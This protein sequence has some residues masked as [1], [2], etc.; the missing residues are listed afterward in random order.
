MDNNTLR[1]VISQLIRLKDIDRDVIVETLLNYIG[2][3]YDIT[4]D[5]D[6]NHLDLISPYYWLENATHFKSLYE[7]LCFYDLL[8]FEDI[9]SLRKFMHDNRL[10]W[11]GD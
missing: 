8:I 7:M 10:K 2:N 11:A 6:N 9:T 4:Y 3:E 1:V 5:Y